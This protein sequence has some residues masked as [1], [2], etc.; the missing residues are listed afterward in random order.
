MIKQY[1]VLRVSSDGTYP[2][3]VPV[4]GI[5]PGISIARTT[6][7][8]IKAGCIRHWLGDGAEGTYACV[9]ADDGSGCVFNLRQRHRQY[10]SMQFGEWRTIR[11]VAIVPMILPNLPVEAHEDE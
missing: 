6:V 10:N 4:P 3:W 9:L 8:Q 7:E 5:V 2:H 11:T 1:M